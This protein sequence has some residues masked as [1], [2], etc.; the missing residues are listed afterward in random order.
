MV[1]AERMAGEAHRPFDLA[2]GPLLR[3]NQLRRGSSEHA[4]LLV[5][6]HLVAD[7]WSVALLVAE[8]V[9]L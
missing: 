4:L 5:I 8:L 9:R 3:V 6:H 1:V 7:F 2:A